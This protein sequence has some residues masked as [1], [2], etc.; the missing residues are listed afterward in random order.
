MT[1]LADQVDV[2]IGA[3][4]H[5][6][7]HALALLSPAGT[8]LAAT[9][10]ANSAAGFAA[11]LAWLGDAI[12][13]HSAAG[14]G[15]GSAPADDSAPARVVIGVEGTRSYGAGLSRAFT[16]AGYRVV[17]VE[18]PRRADRAGRGKS[19]PIDAR[20]AGLAVLRMPA[21]RITQ[22]RAD[23]A[24]EG[25]RILLAARRDLRRQLV[26]HHNSLHHLLLLGDDTDRALARRRLSDDQLRSLARRRGPAEENIDARVR[27][28]ELRRLAQAALT[29]T[30]QLRTNEKQL[31]ELV[32][33]LAEHLLDKPGVGPISAAQVLV[34]WS[35]PGRC[36]N[37]AAFAALA[38]ASPIPAS[39]GRTTRHRLN[40]GGDRALNAALHAIVHSRWCTDPRTRAYID[41]RRARGH[42]DR[43]IKRSLKR[44][45]AR[46]LF[47]ALKNQP[48][49]A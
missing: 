39:S 49:A 2:V 9:T 47:R 5:R 14:A 27:R 32:T 25:L 18:R 37:E 6:D 30:Q 12:G 35:H 31:A 42:N 44:Y 40:R 3:D 24:R 43:E 4:T 36:R 7:T 38:G 29:E 48:P 26:A 41:R 13:Q 1:M 33:D 22:P 45:V 17:E 34:S 10:V 20:L 46:E 23:G 8:L 16:A 21:D 11:A 15:A 28:H 19:D